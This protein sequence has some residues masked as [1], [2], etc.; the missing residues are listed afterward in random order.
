MYDS[1]RTERR[2]Y[3]ITGTSAAAAA[4]AVESIG[5]TPIYVASTR[6]YATAFLTIDQ[7][8]AVAENASI[9]TAVEIS[10]PIPQGYFENLDAHTRTPPPAVWTQISDGEDVVDRHFECAHEGVIVNSTRQ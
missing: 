4:A 6:P 2:V 10:T 9:Q 8:M 7:L 1:D 3:Q 5:E